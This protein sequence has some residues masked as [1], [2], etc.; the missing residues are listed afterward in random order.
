MIVATLVTLIVLPA[1]SAASAR[2]IPAQLNRGLAHTPL[3]GL[4]K[5]LDEEGRRQNVSPFLIAAIA[6]LE[7]SYGLHPCRSNPRNVWGLASC[8]SGYG[9]P[10]FT[11]WRQAV[12]YQ[13]KLLRRGWLSKGVR[14]VYTIGRSYCPPCGNKWGA[15]VGWLMRDLGGPVTVTYR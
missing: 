15:D 13:A 3:R 8:K 14:D 9:I 1:A 11:S 10:Y 5:V 4:G 6:G 7:S 2:S 12:R